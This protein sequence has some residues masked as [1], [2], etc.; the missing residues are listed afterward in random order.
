[1][2]T[3]KRAKNIKKTCHCGLCEQARPGIKKDTKIKSM[4]DFD[5]EHMNSIKSLAI[6]VK[7]KCYPSYQI[8]ERKNANVFKNVFAKFPL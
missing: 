4:I 6:E 8:Y 1:M 5:E 3:K 2:L 7:I